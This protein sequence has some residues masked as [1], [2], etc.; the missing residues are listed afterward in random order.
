MQKKNKP[1]NQKEA[2]YFVCVCVCVDK[3]VFY[4][5]LLFFKPSA[6]VCIIFHFFVFKVFK[7]RQ[8]EWLGLVWASLIGAPCII[9]HTL[10][11]L[12]EVQPAVCAS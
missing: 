3:R 1:Q 11:P 10:S 12:L 5:L 4:Y 7:L 6:C 2:C 8:Q 9:T